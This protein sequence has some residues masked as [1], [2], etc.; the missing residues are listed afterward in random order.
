MTVILSGL[1]AFAFVS[2]ARADGPDA[3]WQ[4]FRWPWLNESYTVTQPV[5][6]T[7]GCAVTACENAQEL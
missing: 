5:F 2:E 6:G 7:D 1:M 4:R 3:I